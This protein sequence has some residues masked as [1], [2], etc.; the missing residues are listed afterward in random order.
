MDVA[1]VAKLARLKLDKDEEKKLGKELG[2]VL[3]YIEKLKEV[4]VDGVLELTQPLE[5]KNVLRDDV[6]VGF[7]LEDAAALVGAAPEKKDGYVR[8]KQIFG[9]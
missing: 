2:T 8:V 4:N 9:E 7:P 3:G 5:T 6:V 1:K